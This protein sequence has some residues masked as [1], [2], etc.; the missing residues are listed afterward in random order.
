MIEYRAAGLTV[1]RVI[2]G[3]L[4]N[5]TW[6]AAC[7]QTGEAVIIDAAD[8][9]GRILEAA[10]G[11]RVGAILT[12]HGHADHVQ[13]VAQVR[14]ALDIPYRIHPLDA[15]AAGIS[16][17]DP[18]SEGEHIAVGRASLTAVHTP[19]HTPGSTC[20]V[21]GPLLFSG[22]TLF[23]GGPGATADPD[24][25]AEIMTSLQERLFALPDDTAVLPG[26]GAPTTIGDER[27]SVP[28]WWR[29]GW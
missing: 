19:G 17:F 14:S 27:P 25:F 11:Y 6:I 8:E 20:F 28:E 5:N 12:T 13:A 21:A 3:P 18:I 23:P 16:P 1:E 29:R 15:P 9:A 24:R 10:A 26:H 4:E 2:V 22:D 7:E